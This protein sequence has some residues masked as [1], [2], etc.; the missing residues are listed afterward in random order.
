MYALHPSVNPSTSL[1]AQIHAFLDA[2][3][4]TL[5][6]VKWRTKYYSYLLKAVFVSLDIPVDKLEFVVGSSFELTP[7]YT[8][9]MYKYASTMLKP[10]PTLIPGFTLLSL[11][12]LQSTLVPM[13]SSNPP[14]L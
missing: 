2:S 9:D 5:E 10:S 6:T 4:S 11:S 7:E 13:S 12:R 8:L 3:K 14:V 1:I